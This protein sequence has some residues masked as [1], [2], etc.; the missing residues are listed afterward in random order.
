MR[1]AVPDDEEAEVLLTGVRML[2]Q[3]AAVAARR[4][5]MSAGGAS[6]S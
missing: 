6:Y 3:V 4:A 2:A 1:R 5:A